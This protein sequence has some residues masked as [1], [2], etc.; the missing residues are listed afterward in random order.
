M[1]NVIKDLD[2]WLDSLTNSKKPIIVEG[3][4]DKYALERLG[5]KGI[6]TLNKPLFS[7]IEEIT[8]ISRECI[9]LVDLDREGK[10]LYSNLKRDLERNGIRIDDRYRNFLFKETK[11]RNIEG[12]KKY[13]D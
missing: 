7:I 10:K 5:I 13:F 2:R 4:K 11:I 3:K 6:F 12:L 8:D 9:L 1:P